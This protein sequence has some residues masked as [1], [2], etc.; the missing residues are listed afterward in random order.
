MFSK[1][2]RIEGAWRPVNHFISMDACTAQFVQSFQTSMYT[3]FWFNNFSLNSFGR[4]NAFATKQ[5]LLHIPLIHVDIFE[6]WITIIMNRSTL[7]Y[8]NLHYAL[9][10]MEYAIVFCI[11]NVNSSN[12]LNF[13]TRCHCSNSRLPKCF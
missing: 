7:A 11:C 4:K 5:K 6:I 9:C 10:T 13:K 8:W 3:M 1:R 12:R 2:F